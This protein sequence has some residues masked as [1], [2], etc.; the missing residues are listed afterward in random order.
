MIKGALISF[1]AVLLC[2][3]TAGSAG[4]DLNYTVTFNDGKVSWS[5]GMSQSG[6]FTFR[7]GGDVLARGTPASFEGNNEALTAAPAAEI[8]LVVALEDVDELAKTLSQAARSRTIFPTVEL[9]LMGTVGDKEIR[10]TYRMSRVRVSRIAPG[11]GGQM[12]SLNFGEITL[13]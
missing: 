9:A 4:D 12:V 6:T 7:R 3:S 1:L 13:D 2:V 8:T 11:G 10:V 5:W